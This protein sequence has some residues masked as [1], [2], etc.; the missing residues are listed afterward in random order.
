MHSYCTSNNVQTNIWS[1]C[2]KLSDTE[3]AP[4]A[5][6]C[7]D[8]ISRKKGPLK[9]QW[10][11]TTWHTHTQRPLVKHWIACRKWLFGNLEAPPMDHGAFSLSTLLQSVPFY[12]SHSSSRLP[13]SLS[14][15]HLPPLFMSV[16]A[17]PRSAPAH[18]SKTCQKTTLK[19]DCS[20]WNVRFK[21]M[22]LGSLRAGK[23][24]F[25]GAETRKSPCLRIQM[26]CS[27]TGPE[28]LFEMELLSEAALPAQC[29]ITAQI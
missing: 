29:F 8:V 27:K 18:L 1:H 17:F 13:A 26:K 7:Q 24:V 14:G 20:A 25:P 3:T 15:S 5:K 10:T 4:S 12:L 9:F 2:K 21:T 28:P 19:G 16:G 6:I 11:H 22:S 23:A